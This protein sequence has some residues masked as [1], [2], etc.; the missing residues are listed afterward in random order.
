MPFKL[1]DLKILIRGA[2]EMATGCACRLHSSGFFRILMTEIDKPLAVRRAVSFCEAVHEQTWTVEGIEAIRIHDVREIFDVWERRVIPVL[3]DPRASSAKTLK[4]DILLDAIL[5]KKN[6]G[7]TIN[8]A[9]LVIALG[10]G[11]CAGKDAHYVIETDRGHNLGRL[12]AEGYASPNTGVPGDIA[13]HS[14]LR[15][16]RA[17]ADGIF[18]SD[19]SIGARVTEGQIIGQAA[20]KPVKTRLAGILRGLIRPGSP[21]TLNL[22]IGDVAPRGDLEYCSTISEKARAIGGTVLE[23]VLRRYNS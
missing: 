20:G 12:M 8:D 1:S 13:G 5:A 17:P 3:V 22:K 11:F 18:Q 16:L 21:V 9:P 19:L 15:V 10:P 4:P 6:E 2:G 23:A 7:T 14:L